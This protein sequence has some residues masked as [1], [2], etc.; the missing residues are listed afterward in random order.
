MESEIIKIFAQLAVNVPA[1]FV[2]L[3]VFWLLARKT[4][5]DLEKD[6]ESN[7]TMIKELEKMHAECRKNCDERIQAVNADVVKLDREILTGINELRL[8]MGKIEGAQTLAKDIA[9]AL[10]PTH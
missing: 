2:V 7:K 9:E 6:H 3:Y 10:S 4:L 1:M 8:S 5:S